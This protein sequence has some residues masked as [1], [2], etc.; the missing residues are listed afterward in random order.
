MLVAWFPASDLLH[1]R[2]ELAAA[3]AH[4]H[5]VDQANRTLAK[6]RKELK[7]PAAVARIAEQQYELVT[8]GEHAYQVLPSSG[9]GG[10]ANVTT[11]VV[12]GAGA[13]S[14][15]RAATTPGRHRSTPRSQVDQPSSSFFG[16]VLQTLEFW[17]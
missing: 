10:A 14:A 3:S 1:Q 12:A 17:R 16:R 7:T 5:K 4:L 11:P 15:P 8:P 2:H 13:T 9:S 6:Q